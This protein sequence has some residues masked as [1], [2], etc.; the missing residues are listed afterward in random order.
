MDIMEV[1]WN[2]SAKGDDDGQFPE[3]EHSNTGYVL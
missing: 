3:M 2:P 1:G